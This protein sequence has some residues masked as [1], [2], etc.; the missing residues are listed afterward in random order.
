MMNGLQPPFSVPKDRPLQPIASS[1]AW[2]DPVWRFGERTPGATPHKFLIRWDCRMSRGSRFDQPQWSKWREAVKIFVWSLLA[3]PPVEGRALRFSTVFNK[4]ECMRVLVK[5]MVEQGCHALS[6]LDED[7]QQRFLEDMA[8]RTGKRGN[9]KLSPGALRQYGDTLRWLHLQGLKYSQ[10]AIDEPPDTA[11]IPRPGRARAKLPYTP[12]EIA[13]PLVQGAFRLLGEPADDVIALRSRAEAAYDAAL[14]RG[15]S[16]AG[17]RE[18]ALRAISGFTF[19]TLPDE[20]GPWY[21]PAIT[22]TRQIRYLAARI[23]DACFVLISYLVGM[24]VSEIL[25]LRVGCFERA[26]SSD[27]TV[28]LPFIKGRIYKT[29]SSATGD[30][31]RWIAPEIAERVIYVLE[32]LSAK[33]RE[34]SGRPHLWLGSRGS[35]LLGAGKCIDILTDKSMI[36]RLNNK[37]AK[38]VEL[39]TIQGKVWHLTTHQGRKTFARFIAKKDHTGLHALKSHFGHHSVTMTDQG[40]AGSDYELSE[41]YSEA[42]MEEMV[43]T[44]AEVLTAKRLAGAAGEKMAAE[45]RGKL[46]KDEAREIARERLT[47]SNIRIFVCEF[48]ICYY[49]PNRSAC[50]GNN[51][52]PNPAFRSEST[53]VG[54]KNFL[55]TIKH[56][57]IWKDRRQGYSEFLESGEI[58]NS[59]LE[60]DIKKKID[61]CDQVIAGLSTPQ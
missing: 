52:G 53:C 16:R 2:T 14:H 17:A 5:W 45:F 18:A 8:K 44:Y 47:N 22:G 9:E 24:R 33:L 23:Y 21:P 61:E 54:C 13:V 60:H 32:I 50:H 48:G 43:E 11:S 7:A 25:G 20:D 59:A 1:S 3:D 46:T 4:Y 28:E 29:A 41:L 58:D 55:V 36:D 10:L 26:W 6:D 38:F 35:G 34:K 15:Q 49:N 42:Q 57:P 12:D 19:A 39:P 37:F 31:H 40:Y 56:L 27:G 51:D 30:L